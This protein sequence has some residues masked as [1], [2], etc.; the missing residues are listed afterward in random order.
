MSKKDKSVLEVTVILP[1]YNERKNIHRLIDSILEEM[2]NK[3]EILIVDDNSPDGTWK[4]VEDMAKENSNITLLRRM[5]KR[6]LTSALNDGIKLAKGGIIAWMDTDLSMPPKKLKELTQ[7]VQDGYDIAVGS[8]YVAGGGMMIVTKSQD[9]LLPVVLSY[10]MNLTI[11]K[12]LDSSFRDYTSGFVAVRKEVL[13][14][15]A[16]KGDYG[17]YFIDFIY[18]AIKKKYK[19]IEL[20]Y[21]STAR[22][23]G[24]S[25]TG[26]NFWQY[27]RR[28]TKYVWTVIR[29]K[30]TKIRNDEHGKN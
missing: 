7:K 29:L 14:K 26:V 24:V 27:L 10:I 18:R 9:T 1:T 2:D 3:V 19:I 25:K 28:G 22:M 20:P 16:I 8:R 4:V 5:N 23:Y 13:E 21:I 11:Q 30:L 17:E 12:I 15:I 6:G